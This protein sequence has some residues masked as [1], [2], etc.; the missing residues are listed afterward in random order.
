MTAVNAVGRRPA[1]G[2]VAHTNGILNMSP[3][4]GASR[5]PGIGFVAAITEA[6]KTTA[7][8]AVR[9]E[10][11]IG[12]VSVT[13]EILKSPLAFSAQQAERPA[14]LGRNYLFEA[15][16]AFLATTLLSGLAGLIW[17]DHTHML[18]QSV[19]IGLVLLALVVG[20]GVAL[21]FAHFSGGAADTSEVSSVAKYGAGFS[22]V[23]LALGNLIA[24]GGAALVPSYSGS[25]F[26][27]LTV[28]GGMGVVLFAAF[29]MLEWPRRVLQLDEGAYYAAVCAPFLVVGLLLKATGIA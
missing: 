25:V 26:E 23:L 3:I 18:E 6:L 15:G 29:L 2:L 9:R 24:L 21:A 11:G 16:V 19:L 14:E 10:P 13:T 12:I 4:N 20:N 1:I 17:P 5:R 7:I 8:N 22:L 28:L 27:A